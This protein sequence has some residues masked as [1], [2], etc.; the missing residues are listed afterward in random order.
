MIDED[1]SKNYEDNF[2]SGLWEYQERPP[3]TLICDHCEQ[4]TEYVFTWVWKNLTKAEIDAIADRI[5]EDEMS[6]ETSTWYIRFAQA[7][8]RKLKEKN[9]KLLS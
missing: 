7:V 8:Q 3:H 6:V 2:A 4:K 5:K 9:T 1:E